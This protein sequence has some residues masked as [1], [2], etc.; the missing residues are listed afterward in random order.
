MERTLSWQA[1]L[2][3]AKEGGFVVTFPDLGHGATQGE[4][5]E[6]AIEIAVDFLS[7]VV[8]DYIGSG[9]LLP[10]TKKR[11]GKKYRFIQLP[12]FAAAKVELYLAC[13]KQ[14]ENRAYSD[15]RRNRSACLRSRRCYS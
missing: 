4:T 12:A 7:C 13:K 14:S 6:E 2:E 5:K 3:P 11:R 15:L 10:Q 9:E 1:L 8:S